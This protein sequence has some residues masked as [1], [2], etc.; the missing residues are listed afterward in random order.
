MKKKVILKRIRFYIFACA[1]AAVILSAGS[2]V[3]SEV[4]RAETVM[5]VELSEK[6]SRDISLDLRDMNVVDVYKFLAVKGG[7]NISIS[8]NI[9]GRVTLFLNSVSIGDALDIISLANN[10]GYEVMGGNTIY[11]MTEAE[12]VSMFGRKFSDKTQL[13]VVYLKY[14]KPAYI[15]EA[16]KNIKSDLGKVVIDE[17]TGS[18]VMVDTPNKIIEMEKAIEKM[19]HPLETKM[20]DLKYASAEDIAQKLKD[21]LEAKAVG[22]VSADARSNRLIVRAFPERIKE[23]DEIVEAFDKKTKAVLIETRILKVT[24]NPSFDMGIDWALV[25]ESAPEAKL[26]TLSMT[27]VFPISSAITTAIGEAIGVISAGDF[28]GLDSI[29]STIKM[30][31]QVS[32]TKVLANPRLM[33][34]NNK[35][36]RI[37][38]GDKLA[39]VTTTTIGTGDSQRV[40][41]EIHYIDVGVQFKVTPTINDDGYITMQI[42]PEISSKA[43]ELT[44]P[45][46]AKIPLINST[47]VESFVIVKD[48]ETIIIGGLRKDDITRS[49][50]G[51]PYLMD[52]PWI[53]KLFENYSDD[54]TKT[55]IV[56]LLTPHVVTGDENY[57]DHEIS[58]VEIR[59]D[60]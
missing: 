16:L 12:Y 1:A 13:K 43:D 19:D 59:V 11:V 31:K 34:L 60:K 2:C 33:V 46:G 5:P 53:G 9:E 44:T 40:N 35:E 32:E 6:L 37:H 27:G 7:F 10:L 50:R 48:G 38:I 51:I 42:R 14:A 28:G 4:S 21:K 41:E 26:R 54:I 39:Y 49:R 30:L 25:L 56:I 29:T 3:V 22:T 47:L 36:A 17:D 58:K 55:E 57:A 45:Q 23:V 18:V 15:L 8:K 20:Y 52:A 24:L